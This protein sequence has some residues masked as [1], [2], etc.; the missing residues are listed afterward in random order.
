[1]EKQVLWHP[2]SHPSHCNTFQSHMAVYRRHI[3]IPNPKGPWFS[4]TSPL[5]ILRRIKNEIPVVH[6]VGLCLRYYCLGIS[7]CFGTILNMVQICVRWLNLSERKVNNYNML[8][9]LINGMFVFLQRAVL[10]YVPETV[11]WTTIGL[12]FTVAVV[13]VVAVFYLSRKQS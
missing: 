5:S 11:G 1:M 7:H 6:F 2:I 10:N 3:V 8:S 12:I 4:S 9:L 13:S